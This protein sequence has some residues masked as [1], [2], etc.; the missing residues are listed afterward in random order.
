MK[1][2]TVDVI[3]PTYKP[4][5]EFKRLIDMLEIQSY[6]INNIIVIN[7]DEKYFN[8]KYIEG[9]NNIIVK[10]ITALEFD[11]GGTRA[12][13]AAMSST[14]IMLFMTQDAVPCD[15]YLVQNLIG[16]FEDEGVGAAYARQLPKP[17]CHEIEKFT[18]SFNYPDKDKIKSAKDINELGIKTYFCSNV[19]AAYK[20]EAYDSLGGFIKKTIFNEDMIFAGRLIKSGMKIAYASNALVLH[21]HNYGNIEQLRRNFD[22]AVSQIDNPEIFLG[23]KSENEGIKLV[24]ET[25]IHCFKIGKPYLVLPLIIKSGFK[26]LGYKLG[27]NYKA[28]PVLIVRGLSMNKRYWDQL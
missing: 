15:E 1:S 13:A 5:G 26:Y 8:N 20:K 6:K 25:A 9:Y 16:F 10:H 14:D 2:F 7:T 21:S 22:L 11:H 27:Y 24:K 17:D 12:M 3:I 18:R 28:L 4:G 19:C 23:L